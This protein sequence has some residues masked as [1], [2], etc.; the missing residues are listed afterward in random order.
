MRAL[1]NQIT[2]L[3]MHNLTSGDKADKKA[4]KP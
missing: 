3:C 1:Q 2:L 4:S